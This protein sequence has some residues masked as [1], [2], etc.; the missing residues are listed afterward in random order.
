MCQA[1][2][3]TYNTQHVIWLHLSR[4]QFRGDNTGTVQLI[5]QIAHQHSLAGTDTT[6]NDNEAFTLFKAITQIGHGP[7]M[8]LAVKEK[9]GIGAELKGLSR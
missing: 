4:H 3:C 5:E 6:G 2:G 9:S 7:V 8:A 1:E